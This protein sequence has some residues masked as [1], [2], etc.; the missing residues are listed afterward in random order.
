M[1][2]SRPQHLYTDLLHVLKWHL[3]FLWPTTIS[4][5]HMRRLLKNLSAKKFNTALSDCFYVALS[6]LIT[7]VQIKIFGPFV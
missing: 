4:E 6:V 7:V 3:R 5:N 2:P 1:I